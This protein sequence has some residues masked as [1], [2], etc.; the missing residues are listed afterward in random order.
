M[1][2]S[3]L[4][5]QQVF[6][7]VGYRFDLVSGRMLPTQ[8][9]WIALQ[10]KL[11]FIKIRSSCTVRQFMSL[12]GLLTATE[13]QLLSGCLHLRPIQWHLKC[14]WHVPEVLEKIIPVPQS[15]HPH[16]DW[17]LDENNVLGGQPLHPL[18]HAL[19]LF[20]D[21]SNEG[22]GAH[23]GDP[24]ARG[25]WSAIE[26][27]LN[28]NYLELKAVLLAL[29]SFQHLC[30]DHIV[31]VATDNT[32]LLHKQRG[33]YE[34]SLC[35]PME[36]S[37]LVP[38]QR[39]SPEGKTHSRS[40]EC[41][42]GQA[43]QTQSSDSNR[44][45]PIS[46]GVQSFVLRPG[47]TTSR[48]VCNPVQSQTSSVCI[49]GTGSGSL[50]SRR[51]QSSMGE[52]GCVHLSSSLPGSPGGFQDDGSG[53]L[54][55]DSHCTRLAK[56]ALV[57]G[58]GKFVGSDSLQSSNG[59]GP[60]DSTIQQISPQELQQSESACLAPR[61]SAI[62]KHGFSDEVA[63]RI[64]ALQRGSTRA[65][66]KSKWAIFVKWCESHEVGFRS[67]S[68]NQI[69]DFLLHL[70][71]ERNLQPS[72]IEG[73]RTA[74]AD[75]MGRLARMKTSLIFWTALIEINLKEDGVCPLGTSLW[76]STS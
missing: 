26:S 27:C 6:N 22:W 21:A 58:P 73:Y 40:L 37:I 11:N 48:L 2:K 36:A 57:L 65:V 66:Y 39:N 60:G 54:E 55:N 19:Q 53:L 51:P 4:E 16:L 69:A 7:F 44:V 18:Q 28:I 35:P 45:V 9:R 15:L 47:P 25:D 33:R 59:K 49:T 41:D 14:H 63:E 42:S 10:E 17:W 67:P 31:L 32:S 38:S 13:K 76:C 1:K 29:K 72:T 12:I 62:Q 20:T 30:R 34:V 46:A 23:L 50:G 75:M 24:T 64:E 70:F 56:H 43:F 52:F 8:D 5:P 68:V 61:A 74:I 3:E 71:K